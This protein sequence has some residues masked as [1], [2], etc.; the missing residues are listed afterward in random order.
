MFAK[1]EDEHVALAHCWNRVA[2]VMAMV[3]YGGA[4]G[5]SG[6]L[7]GSGLALDWR[8]HRAGGPVG[9]VAV[10]VKV[11]ADWST[12]AT[13]PRTVA[14]PDCW[15]ATPHAVT[16]ARPATMAAAR[17]SEP[18]HVRRGGEKPAGSEPVTL[19]PVRLFDMS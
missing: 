15:L 5:P 17:P 14:A 9:M 1:D 19:S 6:Q 16:P 10:T 2:L 12:D 4:G 11:P 13:D 18:V 8:S 3:T 7:A